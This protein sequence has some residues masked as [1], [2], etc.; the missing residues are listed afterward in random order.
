MPTRNASRVEAQIQDDDSMGFPRMVA[1]IW[2]LLAAISYI[3]SGGYIIG[4]STTKDCKA[5][6]TYMIMIGILLVILECPCCL[7]LVRSNRCFEAIEDR[8][9]FWVKGIIYILLILAPLILCF[10]LKTML[11][12]LTIIILA[13]L[14]FFLTCLQG[15]KKYKRLQSDVNAK[16]NHS[17]QTASVS[18]STVSHANATINAFKGA[19]RGKPGT[20]V[21]IK[22]PGGRKGKTRS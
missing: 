21:K 14:Y 9:P 11:T 12:S 10:C 13:L 6:G 1:R 7:L 8:C 5:A 2:G 18:Y 15:S 22:M 4:N 20:N 17:K 19:A 3:S 16:L